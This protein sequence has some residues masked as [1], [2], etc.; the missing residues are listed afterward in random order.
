MDVD[1]ACI[2]TRV[3]GMDRGME[4]HISVWYYYTVVLLC[5]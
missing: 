2:D 3:R 4:S 1:L 5:I